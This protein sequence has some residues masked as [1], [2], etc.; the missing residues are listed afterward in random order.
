MRCKRRIALL[1]DRNYIPVRVISWKRAMQ[2]VYG[3]GRAEIL[4]F[5]DDAET[6]YDASVV[7]L[8]HRVFPGNPYNIKVKFYRRQVFI[9]DRFQCV[10]CGADKKSELTIDHVL[11]KSRGGPTSYTNCVAA[12]RECNQYKGDRTPEEAQMRL[13]RPPGAPIRGIVLNIV[14]IP[15]EWMIYLGRN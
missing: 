8:T 2:L 9:R 10:Y 11:P 4:C 7:R 13:V 5:Y 6:E 1:L 3:R 15:K 12:C 14:D